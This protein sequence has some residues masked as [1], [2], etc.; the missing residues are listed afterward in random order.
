MADP[1]F[2]YPASYTV[3]NI[4]SILSVPMLREGTPIGVMSL[5]RSEVRPFTDKQI[6]LLTTFADQAAIAIQNVR[7]L[8]E[9]QARNRELTE[10][11]EQQTATG[12]ILRV[13][14]SSPTDLAP[15][16]DA[17]A[18]S[19][20]RLCDAPDVVIVR[21]EGGAL[22][23]AASVGPFG[24]TFGP[25]LTV[26]I[27]RGSVAGRAVL[28]RRT[29]QVDDLA[30]ES[31]D[32][33]PEGKAI[34][35]RY[36]HRTMVVAPLLLGDTA[37]GSIG[38]L[39]K[40]VR[41]FSDKQLA[42]LRTF[43]DQAVIAIENVRLFNE[44]KEALD[45]QKASAE[46]LQVISSSVA[47]TRPVFEKI[48]ES[49]ERLFAGAECGRSVWSARTAP[50]IWPPTTV[51]VREAYEQH[52]PVP[53]SEES[54]TGAAILQRRVVHYPDVDGGV[55]VPEYARRG[56]RIRGNK[57][58]IVCADAL[59]RPGHRR[60]LRRPRDRRRVLRE[61]DRAA[62]DLRRPG[63]DRDPE[64][65]AFQRNQG[66]A[67]TPDSDRRDPPRHLRLT[68]RRRS[69]CSTPSSVPRSG[70]AMAV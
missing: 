62:E 31:E 48:L 23:F 27:R 46:V 56:A 9:L 3:G 17:V 60:H 51:R 47:D 2:D 50:C 54:G 40:E 36:G 24:Q 14:S 68:D 57:S 25:D 61:G 39:R 69:R 58:L 53:L 37:L 63:G 41:P 65:A 6:D 44:T 35:R 21:A 18:K 67:R 42:L 43:A 32:E 66:G 28:E 59:G 12:E 4:R 13:I 7:L 8:Q 52:F 1:D 22:R 10:S 55:D 70:C 29:I 64:R 20:S 19:V 30:A 45:Q 26:P 11:L 15:V 38:M 16:F 5:W 33:Y 34:Q 49:C